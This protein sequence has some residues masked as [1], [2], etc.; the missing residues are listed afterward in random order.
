VRD[1]VT[2]QPQSGTGVA[3][4]GAGIIGLS[5]AFELASRGASVRVYDT[6]EPARAASWAAAGMLAPLTEHLADAQMQALCEASLAMYPSF[7]QSVLEA[8]G[9]DP[10]LRLN[11]I[12]HAAYSAERAA[13]LRERAD[14]LRAAGH[15]AE[16]LSREDVL[17]AEPALAKN[18]CG[19]L[20]VHGEGQIDNRRLGRALTAACQARGVTIHTGIRNL[21][22]EFDARRVL[23]VRTEVGYFAA[24]AVINAAGAWSAQ[25]AGV[26]LE[27]VPEVRPVKGQMLALAIPP[28]FVRHTTWVPGAYLVPRADG[29]LLVGATAEEADDVRVTAA[30]MHSLL[31]A[32]IEAAP[33]LRDF[34][35]TESWAGLRPATPDERPYLGATAREGYFLATGHYRNGILLAPVT[36][37]RLA[38]AVL[39]GDR[40]KA[41]LHREAMQT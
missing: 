27:C 26:P 40:T 9:V 38:A 6:G 4:V 12:V 28:N 31:H 29:R 34:A 11:G 5:I 20:L 15:A 2:L 37:R 19:A 13:Q 23:G 25:I 39:E 14:A 41:V 35:V 36:A 21:T 1:N 10:H 24:D 3:I 7:A 30:G 16:F 18:V 22:L 32:A 33:A 8:S 17:R